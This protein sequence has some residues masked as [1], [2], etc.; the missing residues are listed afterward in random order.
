[1]IAVRAKN[2]RHRNTTVFCLDQPRATRS[3]LQPSPDCWASGD[4]QLVHTIQEQKFGVS[5]LV[6]EET[7][8]LRPLIAHP[9][10]LG[11]TH[12][13]AHPTRSETREESVPRHAQWTGR[14]RR[15][16]DDVIGQRLF[17]SRM[18]RGQ[19]GPDVAVRRETPGPLR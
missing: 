4:S 3:Q 19:R 6:A 8:R 13:N 14:R 11:G 10:D 7:V 16:D 5:K 17:A 1:M 9:F 12:D 2:H 15:L 18:Q